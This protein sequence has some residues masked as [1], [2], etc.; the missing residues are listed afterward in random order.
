[1]AA[2]L[3]GGAEVRDERVDLLDRGGLERIMA[4]CDAA[5][6][7]AALYSYDAPEQIQR[8]NVEGTANV[9]Q[10]CGAKEFADSYTRAPREP[11]DP[12]PGVRPRRPT[13]SRLGA[14]RPLQADQARRRAAGDRRQRETASTRWS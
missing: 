6:H 10:A 13:A 4:D 9:I 5:M 8:I 1:M 2:E 3:A 12:C 11:A 14:E 7:S